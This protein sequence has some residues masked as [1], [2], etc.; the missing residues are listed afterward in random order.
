MLY[1]VAAQHEG[2]HGEPG[3][4]G[5]SGGRHVLLASVSR[6]LHGLDELRVFW[7]TFFFLFLLPLA[8]LMV[9]SLFPGLVHLSQLWT[10]GRGTGLELFW[11]PR[12]FFHIPPPHRVNT[13]RNDGG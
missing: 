4:R 10:R 3:G 12:F 7:L 8:P 9:P 1:R 11:L 13:R 2:L 6:W 5:G